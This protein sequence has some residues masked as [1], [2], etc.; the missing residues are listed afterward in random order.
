MAN[1]RKTQ[2]GWAPTAQQ[3]QSQPV[4]AKSPSQP[5]GYDATSPQ[6]AQAS[7]PTQL[8]MQ[9][10]NLDTAPTGRYTPSKGT[11]SLPYT[12]PGN[13][14]SGYGSDAQYMATYGTPAPVEPQ[15]SQQA[16]DA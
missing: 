8:A 14:P 5:Q 3:P 6:Y 10:P 15:Y 2:F 11:P 12:P 7:A 13:A 4:R 16:I 9:P 1:D